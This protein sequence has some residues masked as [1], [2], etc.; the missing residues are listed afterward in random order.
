[1]LRSLSLLLLAASLATAAPGS[2]VAQRLVDGE[3]D[4]AEAAEAWSAA[5]V[6]PEQAV[7][8]LSARKPE[9]KLKPGIHEVEVEDGNDRS[10]NKRSGNNQSGNKKSLKPGYSTL[11]DR[12]F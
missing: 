3:L 12:L 4:P 10:S 9:P 2:D 6:R 7:E 11:A 8:A 1:M 5:G